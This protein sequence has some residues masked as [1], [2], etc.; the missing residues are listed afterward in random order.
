MSVLASQFINSS[1]F[2]KQEYWDALELEDFRTKFPELRPSEIDSL[3][4]MFKN[5]KTHFIE[6]LLNFEVPLVTELK[7]SKEDEAKQKLSK[8]FTFRF[9]EYMLFL[10]T[11]KK[12]VD[13]PKPIIAKF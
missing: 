3:T 6:Q 2:V 4:K 13:N 9:E 8:N 12:S 1:S 5:E 7:L 11:F 10:E